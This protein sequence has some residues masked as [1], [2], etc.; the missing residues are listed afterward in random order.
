MMSEPSKRIIERLAAKGWS[1]GIVPISRLCDLR[2]DLD[3]LL[4]Q[5]LVR[6]EV[7]DA[8]L[9]GFAYEAPPQLADARS[10]IVVAVLQPRMTVHFTHD[11]RDLAAVVPP[12]YA[13]AWTVMNGVK[14]ALEEITSEKGGRFE[15]ATLPLKTLAARTGLVRYGRNNITYLH[16]G[17]SYHRLVAYFTDLDLEMDQWQE[18]EVL[19]ACR[20]CELCLKACPA[21]VIVQDRFLIH[22]ERCLTFLNEM[23]SDKLFPEQVKADWHNAIVGC[24]RCQE[25]CPYDE[26][27]KGWTEE[28]ESFSEEETNYLLK[29]DFT[30]ARAKKMR[31]KLER[32]GL[33]LTI[34]PRNLLALLGK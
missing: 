13:N 10:V 3:P 19:P 5:G 24:M 1:C 17:G 34:F 29:G 12:T 33:D 11:G 21:S 14:A 26:R 27:I 28:G 16:E 32:C 7:R 20:T 22:V 8:Y 2:N 23:P 18:R 9:N 31:E 25:A 30:D 15:R 6:P 4:A